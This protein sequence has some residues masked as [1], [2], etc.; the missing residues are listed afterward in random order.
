MATAEAIFIGANRQIQVSDFNR[1]RK[2]LAFGAGKTIALWK[3][4][5]KTHRGVYATL[6]GHNAE[7][8][9]VRFI[10]ATNLL[11]TASE[12]FQVRIWR[13][14]DDFLE[15]IQIINHHKHTITT[16]TALPQ[17]FAVGCADGSISIWTASSTEKYEL[18]HELN[19]QKGVYPLNLAL[20]SIEADNYI[21]AVGG[22]SVKIFIYSFVIENNEDILI[23][24]CGLAAVLEGHEDWI[25]SLVFRKESEGSFLLASGSQDRYIRLWRIRTNGLIDNSD[26]DE[27]RLSLLSNKQYKFNITPDLRVAINFEALI[28]GHDDWI[29]SLQW[30]ETRL[31]LLASTADTAVMVWEPD[32][33]C[34]IWVCASRLGELSS[35]G[36]STATGSSGGFWS[37]NWFSHEDKEYIL[38]NG[39]TGS[40]RV[41]CS[42]DNS[43][44]DQSLGITGA[45]NEV[46]DVAWSLNGEYLLSTSLDQTTRLY[47]QWIYNSTGEK[48]KQKTWSE[49]ARPQIHGYD[50][51]CVEPISNTR[52]V[53]GGDEKV[54]RSFD[55]PKGVAQLLNKF[56]GVPVEDASEMVESAALPALG[57]SNKA[58]ADDNTDEEEEDPDSRETNETKNISF[59]I[60][61]QLTSPPLEDQ[62]Q[63][64]TLWPETEKL[65]G[66]G[67]EISC[68]DVSPDKKLVASACRSNNAQH[69]VIRIFDTKSWLQQK[70]N[71]AFHNLT[72]T[73]LKFSKDNKHLLSVSRDRQW[74][75]WERN[76]ESET[77]ELKYKNDKPHTRIIWDCEWT[78]LEFGNAFVTA[79]RDK[80]I[81]IWKFNED[82]KTYSLE[83]SLRFKEPITAISVHDSLFNG[84]LAIALGFES[85]A[86]HIYAYNEVFHRILELDAA[87]TPA[88]KISR[89][90]WSHLQQD[91]SLLLGVASA[92]TSTR[93]YSIEKSKL[94]I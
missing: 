73:R 84:H 48:R 58:T 15:C 88:D 39:K 81:K 46:T 86:I 4:M 80:T 24:N 90:R 22:T 65:Y 37:C 70:P 91:N 20:Q 38:T 47:S 10:P 55:E 28:M 14:S 34:G 42:T 63:R 33:A 8:T 76:M 56:A 54:L 44:W 94:H 1:D 21:L 23:K 36:A 40:W 92:D 35:K 83:N 49:F 12:D 79:S 25:K 69:A 72:I 66:H 11:L 60:L 93:I 13:F 67:Y 87:I 27:N 45:S 5:D 26:E 71:L 52:F 17:I 82:Q 29:S 2:I 6:K 3:P 50:M 68:L 41:W 7:V 43:T 59:E 75:V 85:G 64:H 57:L 16:L 61:S 19:V 62:L 77:F 9:C 32:E 31:Q 74:A 18:S 89:L 78:P 30:H 51:V 53:S